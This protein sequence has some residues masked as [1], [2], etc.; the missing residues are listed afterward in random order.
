VEEEE[1]EEEEEELVHEN[2]FE[3]TC[4]FLKKSFVLKDFNL[5]WIFCRV[6]G[7]DCEEEVL[8]KDGETFSS[9]CILS[10]FMWLVFLVW[11]LFSAIG[12]L[13]V[14]CFERECENDVL[15]C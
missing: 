5:N 2:K 4:G 10:F 11:L 9:V 1:E 8:F 3:N 14:D 12:T 6:E 7:I 15:D 13:L